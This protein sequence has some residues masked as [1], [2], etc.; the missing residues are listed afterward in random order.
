MWERSFNRILDNEAQSRG[1][2]IAYWKGPLLRIP[3]KLFQPSCEKA[4]DTGMAY[5][6]Q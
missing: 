6:S 2:A 5:L 3:K 4:V 1:G